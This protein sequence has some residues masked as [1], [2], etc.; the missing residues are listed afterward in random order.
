MM[1]GWR[2]VF[3]RFPQTPHQSAATILEGN[4]AFLLQKIF[5]TIIGES[6]TPSDD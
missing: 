4:R 2:G 6:I 3:G 1:V 5:L